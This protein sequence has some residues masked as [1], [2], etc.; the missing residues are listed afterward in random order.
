MGLS[1]W[2]WRL[3]FC[4]GRR[5]GRSCFRCFSSSLFVLA[6]RRRCSVRVTRAFSQVSLDSCLSF[7]VLR[8]AIAGFHCVPVDEAGVGGLGHI[9]RAA[10]GWQSQKKKNGVNYDLRSECNERRNVVRAAKICAWKRIGRW[11]KML[12]RFGF[13]SVLISCAAALQTNN[14]SQFLWQ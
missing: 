13:V 7:K 11:D 9:R 8:V 6:S 12:A 3:Q 10:V 1:L 4:F 14:A 5:W 2:S